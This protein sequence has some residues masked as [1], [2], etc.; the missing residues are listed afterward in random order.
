MSD[1][2]SVHNAVSQLDSAYHRMR[3]AM[4]AA[5]DVNL[6]K[7]TFDQMEFMAVALT[8]GDPID[9]LVLPANVIQLKPPTT[10]R[11]HRDAH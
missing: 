3:A 6:I 4:V 7:R 1:V 2:Y 5:G 11:R 8:D 9:G 10:T